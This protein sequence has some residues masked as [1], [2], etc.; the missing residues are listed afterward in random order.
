MTRSWYFSTLDLGSLNAAW[1]PT[2]FIEGESFMFA[3]PAS[4]NRPGV[5]RSRF[6]S[7]KATA[8]RGSS[9]AFLPKSHFLNRTLLLI[10]KLILSVGLLVYL[11][12]SVDLSD[13]LRHFI[14]GRHRL[15]AVA[16]I[17]YIVVV[18]LS[19]VRWKVLLD[20]VEKGHTFGE[21]LNS[22]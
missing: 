19:T 3:P 2:S 21:L 10:V 16:A 22:Y 15:F 1:M 9:P 20:A 7:L 11:L 5:V 17:V 18:L 14:E 13:V 12:Q 8:L 6:H 4:K